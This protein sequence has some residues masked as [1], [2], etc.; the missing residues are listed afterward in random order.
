MLGKHH[1]SATRKR[2]SDAQ[3][4]SKNHMFGKRHS[5]QSKSIM[6][7]HS[8]KCMQGKHH[9][10]QTCLKISA[11]LVKSWVHKSIP[12]GKRLCKYYTVHNIKCFGR[13]EQRFVQ[14]CFTYRIKV[15]NVHKRILL[16]RFT[17]LP[18]FKITTLRGFIEIKGLLVPLALKKILACN[19]S[20]IPI[21]VMTLS[22][23]KHFEKTGKLTF[24]SLAKLRRLRIPS[25]HMYGIDIDKHK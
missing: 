25:S 12:A 9:S 3:A 16:G 13:L 11:S 8:A 17:Y 1:T 5:A 18:D 10:K 14:A 20:G 7:L 23:I 4:G 24:V 15:Q 6:R 19:R 22:N 2:M 21:H